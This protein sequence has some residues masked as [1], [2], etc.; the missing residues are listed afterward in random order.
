M[1]PTAT[2]NGDF[3]SKALASLSHQMTLSS[4]ATAAA[5]ASAAAAAAD[6]QSYAKALVELDLP[7]ID[8]AVKTY[9]SLVAAR[10]AVASDADVL[11]VGALSSAGAAGR[12]Q[13]QRQCT[14]APSADANRSALVCAR[15][16]L[17]AIN[18]TTVVAAAPTATASR[19]GGGFTA[20]AAAAG[21]GGINDGTKGSDAAV[22]GG[23]KGDEGGEGA[24][25][26][27]LALRHDAAARI[28]WNKLV[29]SPGADNGVPN[30]RFCA[31]GPYC[32]IAQK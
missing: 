20:A 12:Q 25:E 19:E 14:F 22:E 9:L 21:E 1:K 26:R 10:S 15:A 28:L 27:K 7:K 2:A 8:T 18:S 6:I 23:T 31:G 24:A 11:S 3:C 17:S 4:D 5:A 16:L 13:Q 29:A 30:H 32:G